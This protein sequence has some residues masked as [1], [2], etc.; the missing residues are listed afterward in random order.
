MVLGRR[1]KPGRNQEYCLQPGVI[2]GK[3]GTTGMVW[4]GGL[5]RA[6]AKAFLG[7]FSLSCP[8]DHL[9]RPIHGASAMWH[10][11]SH[12][13]FCIWCCLEG[14]FLVLSSS[15]KRAVFNLGHYDKLSF[16]RSFWTMNSI[17]QESVK[18]LLSELGKPA[19]TLPCPG[20][21]SWPV[22]RTTG[23]TFRNPHQ[24][25]SGAEAPSQRWPQ[26]HDP[27]IPTTPKICGDLRHSFGLVTICK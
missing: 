18:L 21:Q 9:G 13:C 24:G 3:G 4:A 14:L 19:L 7:L 16:P 12:F 26:E 6:V 10:E 11:G 17:N 15:F 23:G 27:Q 25:W 2:L 5:L 22:S 1:G 20:S 8:A